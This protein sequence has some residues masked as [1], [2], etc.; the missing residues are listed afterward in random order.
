ME[1]KPEEVFHSFFCS[2]VSLSPSAWRAA[3]RMVPVIREV[4]P[5]PETPVSTVRRP[6]GIATS[7]LFRLCRQ[8]PSTRSHA[9][10]S[11]RAGIRR[12]LPRYGWCGLWCRASPVT[13]SGISASSS[14]VPWAITRPPWTPAPGPMSTMRSA[15]FIVSSSCSTTNRVFPRRLSSSSVPRSSSLS[16]GCSP[17]VGSSKTYSTPRR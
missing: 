10:S 7:T 4:F 5:A 14:K 15:R 9:V 12:R 11:L 16:R 13:E 17:I 1:S 2:R 6:L 8:Q 3:R